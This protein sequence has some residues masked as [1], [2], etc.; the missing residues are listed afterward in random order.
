MSKKYLL[1]KLPKNKLAKGQN[2]AKATKGALKL[3]YVSTPTA[4][5]R[6]AEILF[7]HHEHD[8]IDYGHNDYWDRDY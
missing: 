8:M 5:D 1:P 4:R 6:L 3:R 7:K 2:F